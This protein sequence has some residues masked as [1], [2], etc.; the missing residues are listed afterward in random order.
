MGN[1]RRRKLQ[2]I[3]TEVL[4]INIIELSKMRKM[5]KEVNDKIRMYKKMEVKNVQFYH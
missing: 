1:K 4:E 2:K 3:L 5:M